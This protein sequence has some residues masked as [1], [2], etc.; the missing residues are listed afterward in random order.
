MKTV[1][2]LFVLLL[3][4]CM[5][6]F[7]LG[8]EIHEVALG[9]DMARV[10]ALVAQDPALVNAKGRRDKMPIHWAAQGG[11]L[12]IVA[13]L[14]SK[15]AAV[16][17]RNDVDETPLIYAAE[18]GHVDLVKYLIQK[19]ADVNA[20][21]KSGQPVLFYAVNGGNADVVRLLL[22]KGAVCTYN[23]NEGWTLLHT[24]AWGTSLPIVQMLLDKGLAA[25][26]KSAS[27]RTPLQSACLGGD[28]GIVDLLIRRGADVNS[29]SQD[30]ACPLGLATT[31]GNTDAVALLL[32]AGARVDI[33]L[34][35]AD[36]TP[37]HVAGA[38]GFG[39]IAAMLIDK[40]APLDARDHRGATPLDLARRY[41]Q[42]KIAALLEAKGAPAGKGQERK[43]GVDPFDA[44]AAGQAM[45]WYLGHSGWAVRTANHLLVFDYARNERLADEPGLLCGVIDPTQLR[46]LNVTVF[47][48]HIHGDHYLPQVFDWAKNGGRITYVMG[49]KPDGKEGY[50]LLNKR[51]TR[52]VNGLEITAIE[53]TDSGQGFYVVADGVR[54][55]HPGD[56]ANQQRDF[57][58]PF[59]GEIDFLADAGR[60]ADIVFAP[61]SGCSFRDIVSV[62]KGVFY[63]ID[64]LAARTVFPMHALNNE[65][66]YELFAADAVK[67]G[68]AVPMGLA[69]FPGDHFLVTAEGLKW[70]SV[71]LADAEKGCPSAASC[72]NR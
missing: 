14:L 28:K 17:S 21:A 4:W 29:C 16:D 7:A 20:K 49:F 53:S 3:I 47:A 40:G 39:D 25:D 22:A 45:V 67:A 10:Q 15:G 57:S 59:K 1:R 61:V 54:I 24:A 11:H 68:Y 13:F 44:P 56:H 34:K 31:A 51:E 60:K 46:D 41:S 8:A 66:N 23:A 33:H 64:R 72:A 65:S 36:R 19:G 52:T 71:P 69:R 48:S 58:G 50:T 35:E 9:G 2:V 5:N 70:A 32:K 55:F 43:P 42:K 6:Q 38:K 18:G 62:K 26:A 63:T 12:K 30:G 37:L 27:G